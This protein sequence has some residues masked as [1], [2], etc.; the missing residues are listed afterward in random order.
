MHGGGGSSNNIIL[1]FNVARVI[2]EDEER[3]NRGGLHQPLLIPAACIKYQAV[4]CAT[5]GVIS[6]MLEMLEH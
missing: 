1:P 4:V 6:D 3:L 5:A 2:D